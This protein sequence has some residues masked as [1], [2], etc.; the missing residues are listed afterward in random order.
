MANEEH[1]TRHTTENRLKLIEE[2]LEF[3]Y[4]P[5]DSAKAY[6]EVLA[7]IYKY[8]QKVKSVPYY[9]TQHDIILI[10]YG[11]QVF[12][13][14]ETALATLSRFLNE[15]VQDV[16]NSVH[17]LPFYPYSSD[18]GFS[19]VRYKGVCPLKGSWRDI[20]EIRKNYRIMFDCVVNHVSKLSKWFNRYLANS[21]E[22]ENFF[23]DVDPSTDLSNVVRPRTSPLLT[24][25][26]DDEG[27]IRNIW[28]TFGNDQVDL[29]YAN[30]KVLLKVLDV[31]LFY[32]EKGASLIRLDAIAFIWKEFGTPCVHHPKTHELIQLMREVMHAV[33]PEVMVI[34]ETNVPHGENVSYFG[35][36]DDEAQMVYNFALPPLLAF[37]ILKSNTTKL[38]QW[39]KELTLPSDGVCFFNFTASH[40]GIGVRAVNEILDEAEMDFLVQSTI[41]HGGLVSFRAIGDEEVS[42]YELNCSYIDLLTNPKEDDTIRVKRMILS[43]ALVLVM[44]G[45]PG[46]YFHSLV[47]SQNYHEAVRKTRINRSIN[48]DKLNYDNL[49]EL[50]EEEGS[51][52]RVLFKRYK[53]LLSIRINEEAFHPLNKFEILDLGNKVF[54][55]KRYAK[56]IEES[57]LALFNF[58]GLCVEIVLPDEVEVP[59]VDILTH[60]KI[61]SKKFVLEPYQIVWLKEY[62]EKQVVQD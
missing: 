7:L 31:L 22:F 12:H 33:A 6:E 26:V 60:T 15:Y 11:D 58:D 52:Q 25:F 46:I 24:E 62:K 13:H 54:A 2:A 14:G 19:I 53:Q 32:V 8:K 4:S 34:T 1:Y 5:E 29:N 37:S 56:E 3:V 48:R 36:G 40:D 28:T 47:G 16:I 57:V 41:E 20:E 55:I 51:L 18:D 38:T 23:I 9:L 45:V 50:L 43:Q 27:K 35:A 61:S 59:L 42:P 17:I 44:P 49:K 30:Y 10:T 21:P 39:A